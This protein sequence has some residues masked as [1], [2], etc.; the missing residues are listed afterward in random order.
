MNIEPRKPI[1]DPLIMEGS[2]ME[3][4]GGT[5]IGKTWFTLGYYDQLQ[6]V[7]VFRKV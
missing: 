4:N 6:R 7:K 2:S 1:I 3:I 5:G